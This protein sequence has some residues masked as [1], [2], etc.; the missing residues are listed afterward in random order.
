MNRSKFV[1]LKAMLLAILLMPLAAMSQGSDLAYGLKNESY[2]AS[3]AGGWDPTYSYP[4]LCN[5][6]TST[7]EG[8]LPP[9]LDYSGPYYQM[10]VGAHNGYCY[11]RIEGTPTAV[12]S[13][14]FTAKTEY[15]ERSEQKTFTINIYEPIEPSFIT[16][17]L[18]SGTAGNYYSGTIYLAGTSSKCSVVE[19]FLPSDFNI[20]GNDEGCSI[21]NYSP[22]EGTFTFTIKAENSV[23]FVM[24]EFTLEIKAP[25]TPPIPVITTSSLPNGEI[26]DHYQYV[27]R[28]HL[29]WTWTWELESGELP[30]G[31]ELHYGNDAIIA[32]VPT[33]L[34]TFTF[35]LKATNSAGSDT[36]Q[37]TI[38]IEE[39]NFPIIITASLPNG[40]LGSTYFM[41]LEAASHISVEWTLESGELPPGLEL[42][43]YYYYGD[44]NG[45]PTIVGTYTFTVK[46]TNAAGSDTKQFTITIEEAKAPIII[47]A[48]LPNGEIGYDDDHFYFEQLDASSR[49][50]VEWT[51]ESGN[52]PPGLM[53]FS[54]SYIAGYPTI[55]GTFTFTLKAT[56]AA[57]LSA[58]QEFTI[59][60]K[61]AKA[62]ITP[63]AP[64][65]ITANLPNGELGYTYFMSLEVAS[66]ISVEWTL[67][68]G[69]LPPGFSFSSGGI[70]GT[71]LQ[72]GTFTFTLKATNDVGNTTKQF[73]ITIVDA[74]TTVTITTAALPKGVVATDYTFRLES[75]SPGAIWE[76]V[77]GNLPPGLSLGSGSYC[78]ISGIPTTVGT[79]TFTLTASNANDNDTKQFTLTVSDDPN[80]FDGPIDPIISQP[81]IATG[82]LLSQTLNGISLHT[83]G[84]AVLEIYGLKGNLVSMQNFA[85]GEHIVSFAHLPKG[86]YIAKASFGSERKVLRL[87]VR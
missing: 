40:E 60:I 78:Y 35:M 12:G 56:N 8:S 17:T 53:I 51:L 76:L 69:S 64:I 43:N 14:T 39:V 32:G 2:Y 66:H 59:T 87:T 25:P 15:E 22:P 47:T 86:M 4:Y 1:S 80:D 30:P 65:I 37:F 42:N 18:P 20:Y 21:S 3:F 84:D 55:A 48:S 11:I 58:T 73:T 46:T 82:N 61:E 26:D 28:D 79:Y 50:S 74:V 34:G 54:Y 33:E 62:P 9:G 63:T 31:L 45:T 81:Q 5:G 70:S 57:G 67:E 19:G 29:S 24:Q 72:K 52:L 44:I 27:F 77:D 75:T 16:K 49:G 71:A 6:I 10:G 41:S 13:Y 23:G 7:A 83:S 68:S 85:S 38:T 36:K